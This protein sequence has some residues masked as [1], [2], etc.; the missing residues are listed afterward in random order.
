MSA[1]LL[2]PM[3]GAFGRVG[4]MDTALGHRDSDWGIQVLAS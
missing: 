3:G 4:E 2:Q 1:V